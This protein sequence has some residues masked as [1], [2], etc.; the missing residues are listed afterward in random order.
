MTISRYSDRIAI[1]IIICITI[2]FCWPFLNN[3]N[4]TDSNEDWKQIYSYFAATRQ[5]ILIHHQF[6]LRSQYFGG[7]YPIIANP[8]DGSL[9]PVMI[10]ILFF[11][12]VAG[13]KLI[14]ILAYV[15]AGI[16]MYYLTRQIFK[17][18]ISGALFSSLTLS[19]N[20]WLPNQ[21]YGGNFTKIYY[22]FFPL[23][24]FF[25]LKSKNNSKYLFLSSLLACVMLF[26]AGLGFVSCIFFLF[27]YVV[28]Q[29]EIRRVEG[30]LKIKSEYMS[31]FSI[32][33]MLTLLIGAVKLL[34]LI[35]LISEAGRITCGRTSYDLSA[36]YCYNLET[37]FAALFKK[38]YITGGSMYLGF[39]PVVFCVFSGTIYWKKFAKYLFLLVLMTFICFGPNAPIDIFKA[40]W[41][42]PVFHYILKPSKYFAVFIVFL[43]SIIGGKFFVWIEGL[44]IRRIIKSLLSFIL[45]TYVVCNLFFVNIDFHEKLF[46]ISRERPHRFDKFFHTEIMNLKNKWDA[47]YIQGE[48]LCRNAGLLN[49]Y[50]NVYLPESAVPKYFINL[51]PPIKRDLSAEYTFVANP[52]YRGELFFLDGKNKAYFKYFTPNRMVI[53]VNIVEDVPLI[54]N[55]NYHK[56]WKVNSGKLKEYRGL[57]SVFSLPKG[58]YDIE[59]KYKPFSFYLGLVITLMTILIALFY[60]KI[61]K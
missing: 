42:L 32:F 19:L 45:L 51:K 27:L 25:F 14:C 16:G 4:N 12:E 29:T 39:L 20:G 61:K 3:I 50:G 15:I 8:Q 10:I 49:W 28:L 23:L 24:L 59:L 53:N 55:Q 36:Y 17:Y 48:L 47:G 41:H 43:I 11:G 18:N 31:K 30:S 37:F 57:L 44:P 34:P 9:S 21:L 22:Y 35:Q 6:P 40:L 7:G 13:M 56:Y 1:L 60:G 38:N 58:S 46:K 26:Q 54:I 52:L 2:L 33:I 5:T